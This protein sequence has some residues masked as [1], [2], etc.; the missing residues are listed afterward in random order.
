MLLIIIC[1]ASKT[2]LWNE[3]LQEQQDLFLV[4]NT[5]VQNQLNQLISIVQL[6]RALSGG[7]SAETS[8]H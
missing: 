5:L 1:A 2:L 4:E 3:K 8:G 6:Y 7:W